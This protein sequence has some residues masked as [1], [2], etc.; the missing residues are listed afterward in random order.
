MWVPQFAAHMV[1]GDAFTST[2]VFME[3]LWNLLWNPNWARCCLLSYKQNSSYRLAASPRISPTPQG[4]SSTSVWNGNWKCPASLSLVQ[5][6]GQQRDKECDRKEKD[7]VAGTMK[8]T[9]C[10]GFL[11]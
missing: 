10:Q 8:T 1:T 7:A 5:Q 6:E 2:V 4:C 3:T 11:T 9:T